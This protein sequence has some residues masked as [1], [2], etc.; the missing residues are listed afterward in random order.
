MTGTISRSVK[1]NYL[2]KIRRQN[3]I[4]VGLTRSRAN[5]LWRHRIIPLLSPSQG[6]IRA[7]IGHQ[8][9]ELAFFYRY[10]HKPQPL[11]LYIMHKAGVRCFSVRTVLFP[12]MDYSPPLV[13]H[14]HP[15]NIL[16]DDPLCIHLPCN[17]QVMQS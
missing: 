4:G 16:A 14:P 7:R 10:L 3:A 11:A 17:R 12:Q 2:E 9:G 13:A 6:F 8:D 1:E 15:H 5:S